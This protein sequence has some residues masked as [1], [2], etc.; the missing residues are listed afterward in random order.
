[1]IENRR[2]IFLS[3]KEIAEAGKNK[4]KKREEEDG[5]ERSKKQ[6]DRIIIDHRRDIYF[7]SRLP[8]RS[9]G[10]RESIGKS[11]AVVEI[12]HLTVPRYDV[13]CSWRRMNSASR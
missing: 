2:N 12:L 3:V 10:Y 8:L 13:D 4:N 9:I 6:R 1:M 7:V 11:L 5:E